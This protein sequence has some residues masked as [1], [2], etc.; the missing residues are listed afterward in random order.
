MN[1]NSYSLFSSPHILGEQPWYEQTKQRSDVL[2]STTHLQPGSRNFADE[3]KDNEPSHEFL[4]SIVR[5][6]D[7]DPSLRVCDE[8][9]TVRICDDEPASKQTLNNLLFYHIEEEDNPEPVLRILNRGIDLK[10]TQN[11]LT[12]LHL[13][14]LKGHYLIMDELLKAG[15]DK[16]AITSGYGKRFKTPMSFAIA[17]GNIGAVQ[18]LLNRGYNLDYI[19]RNP[20]ISNHLKEACIAG[21]IQIV[22][23]LFNKGASE[24]SASKAIFKAINNPALLKIFIKN[25]VNPKVKKEKK[26]VFSKKHG[27]TLLHYAAETGKD[28]EVVK[29][30][31]NAGVNK[32]AEDANK[33]TAYQILKKRIKRIK[34][35]NNMSS[36]LENLKKMLKIL[37]W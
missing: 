18:T 1:L 16:Y 25:K 22:T 31:I 3:Q 29:I 23:H 34:G 21:N 7:E 10:V 17:S 36:K 27:A 30:L 24:Y 2:D 26:N 4:E 15:A 32:L 9:P 11:N 33:C 37:H 12:P 6:C 5:V 20:K 35:H 28:I 14:A 19:S 8:D 13:A